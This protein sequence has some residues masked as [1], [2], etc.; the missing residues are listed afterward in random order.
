MLSEKERSCVKD[1]LQMV[2]ETDVRNLA[3]TV[4]QN[5]VRTTTLEGKCNALRKYLSEC[6]NLQNTLSTEQTTGSRVHV[7][8]KKKTVPQ[9]VK[10]LPAFYGTC[11]LVAMFTRSAPMFLSRAR[12]IKSIIS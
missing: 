8:R 3:Q 9:L 11:R 2:P 1:I 12:I 5:L 10:K 7:E 6:V 4:T